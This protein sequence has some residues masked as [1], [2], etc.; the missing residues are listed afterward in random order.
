MS[1]LT[2]AQTHKTTWRHSSPTQPAPA[3]EKHQPAITTTTTMASTTAHASVPGFYPS[4]PR[5]DQTTFAGRFKHFMDIADPR[6]LA[7][8]LFFGMPLNKSRELM[9]QYKANRLPTGV[10]ADTMWLAKKVH[11][12]AIHPDTGEVI[13]QPFR[14][15]G[16]AVYGTPIVVAMLLPNPT[17]AR[18]IIFQAL[19]QTHNACVN[20]SNRNAS[21]PT[22]VSDLV[23]GYLGAV[24][25]S[26]SIAVGL[27][28]AVAR[29][30]I[31]ASARTVLSRFVPYPAVA[32]ASTCNMLLMRRSELKT[33]ITVKDHEGNVRGVSKE[34]AKSA[35]FQTMLTRI[36]L[37][38]PLLVIPPALMMVVQ[39][40]PLLKRFPR[41]AIP[42]ESLICVSAFVFGLPF[43]ISLFPQEGSI[44]AASA[45][46]DFHNLRDSEG[47]QVTTLYYNKGL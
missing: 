25:S 35:I 28:Q 45:E 20:Y 27:N 7:P 34:A 16:F 6:C 24:A 39:K 1:N 43:A 19:N 26:V 44:D 36:V 13:L 8:G 38:A 42:V 23:T 40:T 12:S 31:S 32:T 46:A 5:Y 18:T 3:I 21:Q 15:S 33:G 4:K 17:L 14:M 11:D 30:N 37:P 29:A 47:R 2:A 9:Q 22:K 41:L 10:N